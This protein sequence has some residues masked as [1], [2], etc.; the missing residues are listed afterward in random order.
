[1]PVTFW[2]VLKYPL[3][4]PERIIQHYG[5]GFAE[6]AHATLEQY[7]LPEHQQ[8]VPPEVIYH[9]PPPVWRIS[10][11]ELVPFAEWRLFGAWTDDYEVAVSGEWMGALSQAARLR[12]GRTMESF[13]TT[14]DVLGG[15]YGPVTGMF[16][17]PV[18]IVHP[19]QPYALGGLAAAVPVYIA[20]E[21]P[22]L[23]EWLGG[24]VA[25]RAE[26]EMPEEAVDLGQYGTVTLS[27]DVPPGYVAYEGPGGGIAPSVPTDFTTQE[28]ASVADPTLTERARALMTGVD[29]DPVSGGAITAALAAL[30]LGGLV[31]TRALTGTRAGTAAGRAAA[32]GAALTQAMLAAG[33]LPHNDRKKNPTSWWH[34]VSGKHVRLPGKRKGTGITASAIKT[35]QKTERALKRVVKALGYSFSSASAG[36]VRKKRRAPARRRTGAHKHRK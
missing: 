24:E 27:Q 3:T 4:I 6:L 5:E 10:T 21:F 25:L 34:P 19:A 18:G 13:P 7:E 36:T 30:G 20:S 11:G 1:M 31:G 12:L 22:A 2:D 32:R 28:G 15:K 9:D 14:E 29:L 23:W 35:V 26:S 16:D 17:E 33:F 8:A